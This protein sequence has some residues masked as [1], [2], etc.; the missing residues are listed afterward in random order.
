M[1][2][3]AFDLPEEAKESAAAMRR[4]V[5]EQ[6]KALQDISQLV[7]RS[8]QQFEISEPAARAI[9]ATKPAAPQ[10]QQARAEPRPQQQ[11]LPTPAATAAPVQQQPAAPVIR[12]VAP[13]EQR[14]R[15]RSL[16]FRHR[17][18]AVKKAVGGSAICCA[19]PLATLRTAQHRWHLPHL[20]PGLQPNNRR[21]PPTAATRAMSSSH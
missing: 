3:G 6:I 4:A 11:P 7:G 16:V 15:L 14:P 2:R 13:V 21:V 18:S 17:F 5:S 10:P 9:A 20:Q 1:K 12:N 8:T 19:A